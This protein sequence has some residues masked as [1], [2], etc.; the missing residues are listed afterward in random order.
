[1]QFGEY[2]LHRMDIHAGFAEMIISDFLFWVRFICV[3]FNV[4]VYTLIFVFRWILFLSEIYIPEQNTYHSVLTWAK[5]YFWCL[6]KILFSLPMNNNILFFYF[7]L[8]HCWLSSIV[9][10]FSS[11]RIPV[12]SPD[13][14]VV[15]TVLGTSPE[16]TGLGPPKLQGSPPLTSLRRGGS[17]SRQE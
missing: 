13:I 9:F 2:I 15:E 6:D 8:K 4:R 5:W 10:N 16:E 11:L 7:L 3:I 12:R 14:L 1:M 17:N